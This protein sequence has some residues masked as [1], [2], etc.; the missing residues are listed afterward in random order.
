M[1]LLEKKNVEK[2][3]FVPQVFV[4]ANGKVVD[5]HTGAVDSYEPDRQSELSA[6]QRK[7]LTYILE[8]MIRVLGTEQ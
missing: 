4:I 7:E 5:G 8:S 2:L 3:L 6:E 1:E